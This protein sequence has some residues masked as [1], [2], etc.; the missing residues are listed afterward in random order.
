MYRLL[1]LV[2]D[3]TVQGQTACPEVRRRYKRKYCK[4]YIY[5]FYMPYHAPW[6]L[7]KEKFKPSNCWRRVVPVK[8]EPLRQI[9]SYWVG[10]DRQG[11]HKIGA[12]KERAQSNP[13]TRPGW[14]YSRGAA[15]DSGASMY[16]EYRK[17][18]CLWLVKRK[19]KRFLT[20]YV[21]RMTDM[22]IFL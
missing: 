10:Q 16:N 17:L 14:T 9:T 22:F 6:C 3:M 1:L 18:W 2:P 4:L 5:S 13:R 12:C 11:G 7:L 15:R 20:Q 21:V 8:Y 19:R